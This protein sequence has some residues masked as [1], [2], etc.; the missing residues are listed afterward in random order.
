MKI[1]YCG[2]VCGGDVFNK[3]VAES[4]VKPSASAQNFETA[5]IKGFSEIGRASCRER[6]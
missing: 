2:S 3:T 4:K 1:F 6:V 5:L